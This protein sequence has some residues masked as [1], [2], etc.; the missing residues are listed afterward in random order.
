MIDDFI[1]KNKS[2]AS[3]N[4]LEN[5]CP[6]NK[7]ISNKSTQYELIC[8]KSFFLFLKFFKIIF[9]EIYVAIYYKQN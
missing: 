1:T 4:E 6:I 9:N 8:I 2:N 5:I 3:Q 7:N